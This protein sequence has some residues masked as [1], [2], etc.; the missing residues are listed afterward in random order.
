MLF[1]MDAEIC[2]GCV[3][4]TALLLAF[5][6]RPGYNKYITNWCWN[7]FRL[8]NNGSGFDRPGVANTTNIFQIDDEIYFDWMIMALFSIFSWSRKRRANTPN[9]KRLRICSAPTRPGGVKYTK[10]M[11]EQCQNMVAANNCVTLIFS[12]QK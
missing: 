7:I 6:D 1:L 5:L 10:Y 11:S 2:L 4:N 9:S 8:N 3:I 12:A